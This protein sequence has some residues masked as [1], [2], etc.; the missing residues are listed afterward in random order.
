MW[1]SQTW[2]DVKGT[3]QKKI[4]RRRSGAFPREI[5]YRL[6]RMFS[7]L[8]DTVLDPFVGTGT[9][10]DVATSLGRSCIGLDIDKEFVKEAKRLCA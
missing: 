1:F 6:I 3:R 9:T 2:E 8:G 5:P 4:G 10:V 7:I